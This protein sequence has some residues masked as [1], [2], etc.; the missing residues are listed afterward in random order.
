MQGI[1]WINLATRLVYMAVI[2]AIVI[3]LLM[4]GRIYQLYEERMTKFLDT[5]VSAGV[6]L[7]M[8]A[9]WGFVY[10]LAY[11]SL[12][13]WKL[14]IALSTMTLF[15]TASISLWL[16][17]VRHLRKLRLTGFAVLAIAFIKLIF[18]D[19]SAL[20]LLIRAILFITIG[21]IGML[22]SGRLLRK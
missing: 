5:T 8:L 16:S 18:F 9:I 7:V 2:V 1:E 12:L 19:L 20:D 17:S 11:N 6:V 13:D 3:D 14:S 10:Q 15:L 4:K 21:G 22:L